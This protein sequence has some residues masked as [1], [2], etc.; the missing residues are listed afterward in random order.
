MG[1]ISDHVFSLNEAEGHGSV[2]L[3]KKGQI[4][5]F[6]VKGDKKISFWS[7]DSVF[8]IC[9]KTSIYMPSTSLLGFVN[10]SGL[11]ELSF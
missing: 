2:F 1:G 10:L 4:K 6:G 7:K 3:K 11:A 5:S 8:P 9:I